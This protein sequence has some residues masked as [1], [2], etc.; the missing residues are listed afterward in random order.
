MIKISDK[1][2]M[3]FDVEY[4][5]ITLYEEYCSFSFSIDRFLLNDRDWDF[6]KK[7]RYNQEEIFLIEKFAKKYNVNLA[8]T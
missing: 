8:F 6:I 2:S 4:N 1:V 5:T 3:E 7:R